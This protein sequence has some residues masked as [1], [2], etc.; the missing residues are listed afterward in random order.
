MRPTNAR[1]LLILLVVILS[2]TSVLSLDGQNRSRRTRKSFSKKVASETKGCIPDSQTPMPSG[3]YPC[4]FGSNDLLC[5]NCL[6]GKLINQPKLEYSWVAR[7]AKIKGVVKVKIVVNE[8]GR[9]VWARALSDAHP[10]L[11]MKAIK[12]AC[13]RKYEPFVCN[14]RAVKVVVNITYKFDVP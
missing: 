4:E 5:G 3:T 8:R 7:V 12:E 11:K 9:V 1:L 6:G 14:G 10:L 13:Q 2:F